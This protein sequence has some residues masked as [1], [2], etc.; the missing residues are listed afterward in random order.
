LLKQNY[1]KSATETYLIQVLVKHVA[2][3]IYIRI[4]ESVLENYQRLESI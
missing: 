1:V 2:A 3:I 4:V